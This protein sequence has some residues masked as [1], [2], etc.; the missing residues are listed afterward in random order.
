MEGMIISK[1]AAKS[2][3]GCRKEAIVLKRQE[4]SHCFYLPGCGSGCGYGT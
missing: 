4:I 2:V 3:L 1:P